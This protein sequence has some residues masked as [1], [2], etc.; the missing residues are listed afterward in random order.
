MVQVGI[1]AV[2]QEALRNAI[3]SGWPLGTPEFVDN[4]QK[5]TPRRLT[6]SSPGRP[7]IERKTPE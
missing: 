7:P 3:L 2:Q 1:N 5:G 6:K 4:L